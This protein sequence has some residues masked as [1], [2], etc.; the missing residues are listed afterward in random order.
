[1]HFSACSDLFALAPRDGSSPHFVDTFSVQSDLFAFTPS[2]GFSP[3]LPCAF[4]WRVTFCTHTWWRF[5]TIFSV[6]SDYFALSLKNWVPVTFYELTLSEGSPIPN[7]CQ[8][9]SGYSQ[10]CGT[11]SILN[12]HLMRVPTH[13]AIILEKCRDIPDTKY[14]VIPANREI[15]SP[16][17]PWWKNI[18]FWPVY[19]LFYNG[20]LQDFFSH[21]SDWF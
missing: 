6:C 14:F 15:S 2:Q 19:K 17:L 1:M 13:Q 12:L 3:H 8:L 18:Y 11:V 10:S 16:L 9:N 20:C 7:L 4:L 21:T 5:P